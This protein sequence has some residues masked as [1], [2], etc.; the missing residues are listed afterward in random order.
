HLRLLGSFTG[1]AAEAEA[2]ARGFEHRI[3][4]L[5]LRHAGRP[6]VGVLF[7]IWHQPLFTINDSHIIS[8]VMELCGA[9]NVFAALPRLAGEVSVEQVLAIDPDVIVVGSEALDA[10]VANWSRYPW[11][12][13]VR[14]GN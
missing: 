10:G 7:E 13:A 12:A 2:A 4:A 11:L 6:N 9:R 3:E 1:H 5:R 14:D 8:R